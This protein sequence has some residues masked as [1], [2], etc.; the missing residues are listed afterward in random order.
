MSFTDLVDS[1]FH[2]LSMKNAGIDCAGVLSD[3]EA[4][5]WGGGIA[6]CLSDE[7]CAYTLPLVRGR[8]N[9][10]CALGCGPWDLDRAD[11][12]SPESLVTDLERKLGTG[13]FAF[14][15]E[16]GLDAYWQYGTPE[17][18]EKLM[19]LQLELSAALNRPV[20]IHSRDAGTRTLE[21]LLQHPGVRGIFHCYS[22]TADAALKLAG[23]GWYI[24]FAGNITYK[25][26]DAV[27]SALCALPQECV[28]ME[29]DSPY[30]APVP[31]RG[32]PCDPRMVK[33]TYAASAALRGVD[34]LSW[35]ATVLKNFRRLTGE[36]C[37]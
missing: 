20:I 26:S 25:K 5:N 21:I 28:L 12:P 15:G 32:R 10:F 22:Y 14:I 11:R 4:G 6:V 1:H 37:Q 35:R 16:F 3:L 27:R 18:Q 33:D 36:L 19:H 9:I 13:D 7:D 23:R 29:T 31:H 17:S 24:S 2:L 30:L 8:K 34:E